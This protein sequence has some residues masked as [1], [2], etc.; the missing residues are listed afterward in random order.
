M[1]KII[2]PLSGVVVVCD[3]LDWIDGRS[4][5][6]WYYS[7][8]DHFELE[9]LP[10]PRVRAVPSGSCKGF[11]PGYTDGCKKAENSESLN[12]F[13]TLSAIFLPGLTLQTLGSH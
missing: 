4:R 9:V 6:E 8:L 7:P 10:D 13:A 3:G 2:T 12:R 5:L 11:Y 1:I